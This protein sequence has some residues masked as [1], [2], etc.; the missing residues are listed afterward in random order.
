[1]SKKGK[2]FIGTSGY[3]YRHWKVIF[4]P[5]NLSSDRWL[6][7]YV[8]YFKTVELNVTFYQLPQKSVFKSWYK[9]TPKNFLFVCKGN[10]FIT[11]V[12]KLKGTKEAVKLFFNR[13]LLLK[14]K[15]GLILWQLPPGWKVNLNRLEDFLKIISKYK[16][17]QAFE[18]RN[19][20]W[21]CD[22]VFKI[23]KKYKVSLVIADSSQYPLVEKI[24]SSF[25]YLR[26]HGGQILYGSEY[27]FKELK[28]WAKKIKQWINKGL[29]VFIYFNNDA[30]GFAVKNTKQ[31][32]KILEK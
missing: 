7:Y 26:F 3:S 14:E 9:R 18:F 30:Q 17:R 8:R 4:Y 2:I 6:E 20:T 23:L 24:I 1:M 19:E 29:D 21:F 15:L 32:K 16:I 10:R 28:F 12:K 13:V 22:E 11:H 25:V 27:S 31:L 5:K